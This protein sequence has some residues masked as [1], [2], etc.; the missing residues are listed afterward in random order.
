M[1]SLYRK[2]L[3]EEEYRRVFAETMFYY[4]RRVI[5]HRDFLAITLPSKIGLR[6]LDKV[7][8]LEALESLYTKID[9]VTF[10]DSLSPIHKAYLC[11]KPIQEYI[12]F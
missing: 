2:S 7:R 11:G 12:Y 3:E 10:R 5:P 4:R 1:T 9:K 6:S 8:V